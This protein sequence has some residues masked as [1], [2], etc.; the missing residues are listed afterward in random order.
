MISNFAGTCGSAGY[1]GD[2]GAVT[3][4]KPFDP[5]GFAVKTAGNVFIADSAKSS[6]RRSTGVL[7]P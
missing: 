5:M 4:A 3:S 2:G 7:T 6:I 1:S